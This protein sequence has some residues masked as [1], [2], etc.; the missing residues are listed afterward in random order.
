MDLAFVFHALTAVV[1]IGCLW[2]ARFAWLEASH[3]P[4]ALRV[5]GPLLWCAAA[6]V[7]FYGLANN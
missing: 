7:I 3:E 5:V 4:F 6:A 2:W 1:A